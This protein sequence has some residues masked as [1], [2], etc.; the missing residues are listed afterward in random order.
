M[1]RNALSHAVI[2]VLPKAIHD[3]LVLSRELG[4]AISSSHSLSR[5]IF[6]EGGVEKNHCKT[7]MKTTLTASILSSSSGA[8]GDEGDDEHSILIL[9]WHWVD[10]AAPWRSQLGSCPPL[11]ESRR[12]PR[13]QSFHCRWP[14]Q[15]P[16]PKSRE[17]LRGLNSFEWCKILGVWGSPQSPDIYPRA[18]PNPT[19]HHERARAELDARMSR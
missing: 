2:W 17:F 11:R 13:A 6:E 5:P 14:L 10:R 18:A 7:F 8:E 3:F 9:L 19:L 4:N 12:E 1:Y 16:K 15:L